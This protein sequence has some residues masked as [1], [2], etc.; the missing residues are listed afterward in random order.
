MVA[1]TLPKNK[2]GTGIG[3]YSLTQVVS[4]AIGPT[5]GLWLVSLLGYNLTFAINACV[6]LLAAFLAF[7][8]K[9]KFK[10]TKKLKISLS[11]IIAKEALLP[12]VVQVFIMMAFC[13]VNSFLIVFASKQ[14]VTSNIGLY[15]T[16]S[17]ITMVFSRPAVGKLTDRFGLVKVF[18]PALFC[19]VIS[20]FIISSSHTL[21]TF[22][23]AAFISSFGFGA[24]QP[25]IQALAMKCVTN[26]RRGAG[27]STNYIGMDFGNLLGPTI[28]GFIA[29]NFSYVIMW[30]IMVAP[31]LIAIF[32]VFIFRKEIARI[33][34]NFI[35]TQQNMG[36]THEIKKTARHPNTGE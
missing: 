18:V 11:N 34:E 16:V 3:Y 7:Q 30:R 17:A 20:F 6:M 5:I 1:E 23:L 31:L 35:E 24:C 14:G 22:L 8:I 9:M 21:L 32:V 10:R 25:A 2:Y 13:V 27:S 12:A 28:A 15:F 36:T 4:Q 26:E 19:D 33:E 29:Q